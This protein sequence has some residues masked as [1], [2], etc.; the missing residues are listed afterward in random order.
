MP[1]PATALLPTATFEQL[2]LPAADAD[3][4]TATEQTFEFIDSLA[5]QLDQVMPEGEDP[6]DARLGSLDGPTGQF[7]GV[8]FCPTRVGLAERPTLSEFAEALIEPA[9]KMSVRHRSQLRRAA[10]VSVLVSTSDRERLRACARWWRELAMMTAHYPEGS[11]AHLVA[12]SEAKRAAEAV[13]EVGATA[14]ARSQANKWRQPGTRTEFDDLVQTA[15]TSMMTVLLKYDPDKGALSTW[16]HFTL[17]D[18][19]GQFVHREEH[20]RLPRA[21]FK[22]KREINE[23]L[24]QLPESGAIAGNAEELER[25]AERFPGVTVDAVRVLAEGTHDVSFQA[26]GGN[27]ND[28][29]DDSGESH[30][31]L[32]IDK[33]PDAFETVALLDTLDAVGQMMRAHLDEQ[34]FHILARH[35]GL[36]GDEPE[37]LKSIGKN[38][39]SEERPNGY[40]RTWT[41]GRRQ[42]AIDKLRTPAVLAH[43]A[44]CESRPFLLPDAPPVLRSGNAWLDTLSEREGF[45]AR[46]VLGVSTTPLPG[47]V[48]ERVAA[49][50]DHLRCERAEVVAMMRRIIAARPAVAV[51]QQAS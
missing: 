14:L 2:A 7:R 8:R 22:K 18:D 36:D 16:S 46:S 6:V 48:A 11:K 51:T 23:A 28:S 13:Y 9:E 33:S 10:V 40:S 30:S 20:P 34:E 19:L 3:E 39:R 47:T 45:V 17:Q 50:A 41:G 38:M 35:E 21:A 1:A 5:E 27:D 49:A 42:R 4:A 44:G 12:I 31:S 43:T 25:I 24:M 32:L 15:Y 37:H 26:M 29:D